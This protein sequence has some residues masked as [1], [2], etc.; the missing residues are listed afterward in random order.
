MQMKLLGIINDD[1]DVIGRVI[2]FSIFVRYWRKIESIVV[3]Y[4]WISRKYS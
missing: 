1:F 4:V 2:R 3:Q